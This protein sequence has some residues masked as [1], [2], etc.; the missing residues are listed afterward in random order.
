MFDIY[1]AIALL[2]VSII[3][4][5]VAII[6]TNKYIMKKNETDCKGMPLPKKS[7]DECYIWDKKTCRKGIFDGYNC[8]SSA[9]VVPFILILFGVI[10][11]C[12]SAFFAD[13]A[14]TKRPTIE[15]N[16]FTFI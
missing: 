4:F 12:G 14:I 16:K 11:F 7:G 15:S 6:V 2:V 1:I 10:F 3:M 9:S 8:V 13:R 5:I